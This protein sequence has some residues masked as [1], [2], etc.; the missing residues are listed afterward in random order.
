MQQPHVQN[1]TR[2]N[3]VFRIETIFVMDEKPF[4]KQRQ[5]VKWAEEYKIH[6]HNST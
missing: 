6:N 2:R 1:G 3:M 4:K 5:K